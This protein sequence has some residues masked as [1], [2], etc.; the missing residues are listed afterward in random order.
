MS[1]ANIGLLIV[2]F[3]TITAGAEVIVRSAVATARRLRV[4][5][6]IVG[7]TVVAYGT[8]APEVAVSVN[9]AVR[10]TSHQAVGLIAGSNTFN[11]LFIL[12]LVAVVS[13]VAIH[14]RILRFDLPIMV[15]V[16][17]ALLLLSRDGVISRIDGLLML[18][19]LAAYTTFQIRSARAVQ[20]EAEP[21]GPPRSHA[22]GLR[23]VLGGVVGLALL[24]L[25]SECLVRA[26]VDIARDLGVSEIVIVITLLSGGTGLP[27]VATSVVAARRGQ[28]DISLGN[29]VGTNIFN[30]L[31]ILGAVALIRQ[32]GIAIEASTSDLHLPVMLAA[33]IGCLL[34]A[35]TKKRFGRVE[36]ALMFAG[37]VVYIVMLVLIAIGH[38]AVPLARNVLFL[39]GFPL[40][41][42]YALLA[43]VHR[44]RVARGEP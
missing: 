32:D 40:L 5:A 3:A 10:G 31:G 17:I 41:F 16:S 23:L 29:V 38:E 39:I 6:V 18:A 7:L 8:S 20:V 11:I 15:A 42:V 26:A 13:P 4:S 36:G 21:P 37:Y 22:S 1:F 34:F 30:I 19:A 9:A 44:R 25:G 12:G 24:V 35:A 14:R 33:A 2:G 28:A 43:V 27:E